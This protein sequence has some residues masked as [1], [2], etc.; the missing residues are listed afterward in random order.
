MKKEK[1]MLIFSLLI[2]LCAVV[3]FQMSSTYAKYN[4]AVKGNDSA[5][6]A[7]WNINTTNNIGD[8]FASSYTNIAPGTEEQ[9]IIAPGTSGSYSFTID[10]DVETSYTLSINAA[11]V[12]EVN[13]A[14]EGYNPIQ[15]SFTRPNK[16]DDKATNPTITTSKM[17][18]AELKEAISTIDDGSQIHKPGTLGGDTYTIGWTWEIDGDNEKDTLLGNLVSRGDKTISLA[19]NITATQVN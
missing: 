18:F 13:G 16:G 1:V 17:S 6:V 3:L 5:R 10:G 8:L 9:G 12:D 7:H 4:T 14:V 2:L 11:G 19:V 15:Y